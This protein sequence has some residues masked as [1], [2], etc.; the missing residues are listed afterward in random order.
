MGAVESRSVVDLETL[1][2]YMGIAA[3]DGAH[4]LILGMMLAAGKQ[5]ADL[6]MNNR[7]LDANGDELDIPTL[8]EI[9]V[10]QWASYHARRKDPTIASKSAGALSESYVTIDDATDAIGRAH[11]APYRLLP[12]L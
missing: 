6:Y 4:D 5:A 9:G 12:G 7:F 3:D 11:W 8:V 1:K 10:M 2:S